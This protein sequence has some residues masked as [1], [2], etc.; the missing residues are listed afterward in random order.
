MIFVDGTSSAV[1]C[2]RCLSVFSVLSESLLRLAGP[3]RVLTARLESDEFF[4]ESEEF[5]ESER[6]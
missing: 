6:V 4:V 5:R 3:K 1:S 2:K